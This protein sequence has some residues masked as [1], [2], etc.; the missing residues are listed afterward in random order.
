MPAD[1]ATLSRTVD[2]VGAVL[3][4]LDGTLCRYRRSPGEVL[5][6]TFE[7]EGLDPLFPVEAYYEA[8]DRFAA[9]ADGMA[10]LRERC[11]AA[12]CADR[13]HDPAVGRSLARTFADERDHRDV[14]ATPGAH[15]ALDAL[16]G[17]VPLGVVTNGPRDAQA[18]D[19][20]VRSGTGRARRRPRT[21]AVRRRLPGD[22]RRRCQRRRSR[23]GAGRRASGRPPATRRDG[24][25]AP[26]RDRPRR[27][28]SPVTRR[29]TWR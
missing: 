11:F 29:L 2:A 3:F 19:G 12:L 7:R 4:D 6:V 25:L 13:G 18:R 1:T 17:T 10:D 15:A 16:D 21:D 23:L 14:V 22:G 26:R 28:T 20:A 8:F 24:G 9:D 5:A 27:V